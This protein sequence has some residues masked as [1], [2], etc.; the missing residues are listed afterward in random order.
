MAGFIINNYV[1]EN[2]V[3]AFTLVAKTITR[4]YSL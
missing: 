1:E 2:Q 4:F 3:L